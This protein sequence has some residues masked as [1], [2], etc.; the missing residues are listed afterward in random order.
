[1]SEDRDTP[2]Y[3]DQIDVG[4]RALALARSAL[5]QATLAKTSAQTAGGAAE[6]ARQT[7]QKLDM[8][9]GRMVLELGRMADNLGELL[10]RLDGLP[11]RAVPALRERAPSVHDIAVEAATAVVE[12]TAGH[13]LPSERVRKIVGQERNA[14]IAKAAVWTLAALA[15]ATISVIAGHV[16]WK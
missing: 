13:H 1:V 9:L 15:L 2:E 8:T 6:Q 10:L 4:T 3:A 11:T 7:V 12:Q 16:A 14:T 5:S